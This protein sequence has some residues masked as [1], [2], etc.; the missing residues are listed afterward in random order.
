ML[1]EKTKQKT[2]QDTGHWTEM[3]LIMANHAAPAVGP[4]R[5]RHMNS[6]M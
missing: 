5:S 4:K 3:S 6:S 1:L 2:K